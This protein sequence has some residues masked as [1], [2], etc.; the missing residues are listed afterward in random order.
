ML[1]SKL[2]FKAHYQKRFL[3]A[4]QASQ[5]IKGLTG[6]FGLASGLVRK[7]QLA[8]VQSIALYGS[9]IWWKG[10]KQAV[11]QLQKIINSQARAI[12]GALSTSPIDLIV[13]YAKVT[14]AENLL[15]N[16]QRK[17]ALRG[18]KQ[19]SLEPLNELLP[20]TLKYGDEDA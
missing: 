1:D 19:T 5:R 12:I 10:Q 11:E 4:K 15:D 17:Y 2:S 9:E 13:D 6:K 3:L 14:P 8:V 18:L 16:R 20:Q 7:I